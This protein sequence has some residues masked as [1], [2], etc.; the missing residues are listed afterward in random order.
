MD[1]ASQPRLLHEL[2]YARS[3][4]AGALVVHRHNGARASLMECRCHIA[5]GSP[6]CEAKLQD[7]LNAAVQDEVV[8]NPA[9]RGSCHRRT[10]HLG[11]DVRD[12]IKL[13]GWPP[14]RLA[15]KPALAGFRRCSSADSGPQKGNVTTGSV[16]RR[17]RPWQLGRSVGTARR[18]GHMA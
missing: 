17:V 10:L 1:E 11:E 12:R 4:R 15:A 8:E 5:C 16:L 14:F 2:E 7:V 6:M 18:A 3:P 9:T 13:Q